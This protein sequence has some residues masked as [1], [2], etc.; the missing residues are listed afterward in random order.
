MS[1][2]MI[3][4]FNSTFIDCLVNWKSA[5]QAAS[6]ESLPCFPCTIAT[7]CAQP[8]PEHKHT[9]NC[10]STKKG[11]EAP[12][13]EETFECWTFW[14]TFAWL[15]ICCTSEIEKRAK[16]RGGEVQTLEKWDF[17]HENVEC[18]MFLTGLSSPS[19]TSSFANSLRQSFKVTSPELFCKD[20]KAESEHWYK[21]NLT[22]SAF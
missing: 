2:L 8:C 16:G 13:P 21:S 11:Y 15:C 18:S 6:D 20:R 12:G 7:T 3:I 10:N 5:L 22:R 4:T 19:S 9:K 1:H 14:Y 17:T